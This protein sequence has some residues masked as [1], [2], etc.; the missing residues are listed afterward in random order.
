VADLED[1]ASTRDEKKCAHHTNSI[2]KRLQLEKMITR[3]EI[4]IMADPALSSSTGLASI[5]Y[6]KFPI[7]P[8]KVFKMGNT[9]EAQ[10]SKMKNLS[11]KSLSNFYTKCQQPKSYFKKP[12]PKS[13]SI[14]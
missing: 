8:V 14:N 5:D 13:K 12:P 10:V 3:N 6:M 11:P 9:K 7:K 4:I 2:L 1:V